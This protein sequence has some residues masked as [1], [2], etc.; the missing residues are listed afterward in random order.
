MSE[1]LYFGIDASL[2][3]TGLVLIDE[4]YKIVKTEKLTTKSF[5]AERLFNLRN[6]L[7][8]FLEGYKT[9]II[10]TCME[11]YAYGKKDSSSIFDIAEWGGVIRLYL[12]ENN[13]NYILC[14]PMQLKKY[15]TGKGNASSTKDL[16]ILDIYKQWGEEIRNNNIADGYVLSRI[17]KDF[18]T[19]EKK[20]T[21]YQVEVIKAIHKSIDEGTIGVLL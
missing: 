9:K 12:F 2:T 18:I 1:L 15:A 20:L 16:V 6:K 11:N 8:L 5:G 10:L 19:K 14:G 4:N 7:D 17:A 13:M 21:T 3:G